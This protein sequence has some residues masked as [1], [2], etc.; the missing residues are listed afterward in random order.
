MP[1]PTKKIMYHYASLLALSEDQSK[2]III[3]SDRSCI[4]NKTNKKHKE[5][6]KN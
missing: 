3:I 6:K 1:P 4:K 2:N 5:Q